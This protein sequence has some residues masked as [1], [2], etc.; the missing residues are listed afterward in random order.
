MV[1]SSVKDADAA[2]A[3]RAARLTGG[4]GLDVV[5]PDWLWEADREDV[6]ESVGVMEA[7][8]PVEREGVGVCVGVIELLGV[9]DAVEPNEREGVGVFVGVDVVVTVGV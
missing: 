9:F 7:V 4:V 5:L 1:S 6:S 3:L 2:A 8:A